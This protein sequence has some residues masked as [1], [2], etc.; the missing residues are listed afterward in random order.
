MFFS[1]LI[2]AVAT[3][4]TTVRGSSPSYSILFD[5]VPSFDVFAYSFQGS[6][7]LYSPP[8]TLT[9]VIALTNDSVLIRTFNPADI[10]ANIGTGKV[11]NYL[12]STVTLTGFNHPHGI[13]VGINSSTFLVADTLNFVVRA[14]DTA[15]HFAVSVYAGQEGV[16]GYSGD[17][18]SATNAAL[19][20][21]FAG[22]TVGNMTYIADLH[23]CTIRSVDTSGTISLFYGEHRICLSDETHLN[24]PAGIT[25]D[26]S[27]YMYVA[28][29]WGNRINQINLRFKTSNLFLGSTGVA[30]YSP[31]GSPYSNVLLIDH[32]T[33]VFWGTVTHLG[34]CEK[35]NIRALVSSM[36][37]AVL[38]TFYTLDHPRGVFPDGSNGYYIADP[39]LK[40][41]VYFSTLG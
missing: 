4:L 16:E 21:P 22:C 7:S 5:G 6:L 41:V 24:H 39:H 10:T 38:S 18:G 27:T 35:R 20:S 1:F 31:D 19:W 25:T 12:A 23:G 13:W 11:T 36:F 30:G 37:S 14:V 3:F 9:N 8:Q 2:A 15:S 17:G 26:G 29:M 33:C 28:E 32:P 40:Q 34:F